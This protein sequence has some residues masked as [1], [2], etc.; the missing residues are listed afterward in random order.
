MITFDYHHFTFDQ[1]QRG[2]T[3]LIVPSLDGSVYHRTTISYLIATI[4]RD[5]L[6]RTIQSIEL[7]PGDEI[8]INWRAEP[9]HTWG[10]TERNEMLPLARCSWLS[11][12]DDDD[13]YV[14]GHRAIQQNAML[15]QPGG[16]DVPTMFRMRFPSGKVLYY[17]DPDGAKPEV[18][19][20]NVGTPMVMVPNIPSMLGQFG[21]RY[22]GDFDFIN[23]LKWPRRMIYWRPEVIVEICADP[24]PVAQRNLKTCIV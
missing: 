21:M 23:T 17:Q 6:M 18:E 19:C 7:R 2:I 10:H 14:K 20:G 15:T 5:T 8:L 4:G 16:R 22:V 24:K 9:A 13:W 1:L 3:R 11:F 12:I